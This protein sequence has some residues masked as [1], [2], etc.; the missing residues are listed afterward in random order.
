MASHDLSVS[1]GVSFRAALR[2][3]VGL[4]FISFGGPAGQIALMH[5]ALV[6][7][8]RWISEHR[9]L[10][11]LNYCMVLPGPEAQ[12]LATYLGWLM[13]G[14]FGGIIA[15]LCFILPS[16]VILVFLSWVYVTFGSLPLVDAIFQGV[17]PAVIAVVIQ[18]CHRLGSRTLKGPWLW[19][20]AGL[21]LF[22][23]FVGIPFPIIILGA[24]AC[25]WL[26]GHFVPAGFATNAS[27]ATGTRPSAPALIDD[28]TPTPAHARPKRGQLLTVILSG[29][30]LW[31]AA[32]TLLGIVFGYPHL[33]LTTALF[34]TKAALLT[35][36]GAYAVLPYVHEGAVQTYGWLT[37]GQMLDGLAL[38]ETT[39]GPLIMI[40][41]FVGY[42]AGH[43]EA[44]LGPQQ[45][46]VA[47]VLTAAVATGFTFLPSFIFV[48]AGGPWVEASRNKP[49]YT[50][51]LTAISAAVVSAILNLAWVLA[52]HIILPTGE[53]GAI[54]LTALAIALA[55][56]VA[57]VIYKRQV[58]EVL[59]AA[60]ALGA[61]GHLLATP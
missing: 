52:G 58:V 18:A 12:Q 13:H 48:L 50:A 38:G 51:V 27:H 5:R 31:G 29:V 1:Q 53:W 10:H 4:G 44:Y 33:L 60:S 28:D 32:I 24:A 39:P 56:V 45:A 30:G 57:L 43:G 42:L 61:A 21:A 37:S 54:D 16:L 40:V 11:A 8:R 46:N 49:G 59:A 20:L 9:F 19:G 6:D 41:S 3:W 47:G 7:E 34:F 2:F 55:S 36:G 35:F 15:G 23:T 25:G 26:G 14:T 22:A 17:K